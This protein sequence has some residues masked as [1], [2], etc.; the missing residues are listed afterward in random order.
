M[1]N[2]RN[3]TLKV[4]VALIMRTTALE[5]PVKGITPGEMCLTVGAFY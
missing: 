4:I 1:Q 3:G 2:I 5:R